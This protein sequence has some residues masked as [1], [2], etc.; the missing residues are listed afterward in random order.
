MEMVLSSDG[1]NTSDS[2]TTATETTTTA[3]MELHQSGPLSLPPSRR[4]NRRTATLIPLAL[5]LLAALLISIPAPSVILYTNAAPINSAPASAGSIPRST[6]SRH[7]LSQQRN[8][9]GS[10]GEYHDD[11]YDDDNYSYSYIPPWNLSKR[12]DPDGFLLHLYRCS[13]GEWEEE[14]AVGGRYSDLR[15]KSR[16]LFGTKSRH[17]NNQAAL[18]HD[19]EDENNDQQYSKNKARRHAI[20]L[21]GSSTTK[22]KKHQQRNSNS[23]EEEDESKNIENSKRRLARRQLLKQQQEH[24]GVDEESEY[25]MCTIRQVPGDGNCLFHSVSTCLSVVEDDTS[26]PKQ[27]QY[28]SNKHNSNSKHANS[29]HMDM[30][31]TTH[32]SQQS[33]WLRQQA[34]ECL[35]TRP[36]RVLFLQGR[37][38]LRAHELVEAAA[39]QYNIDATEYCHLMQQDSYWGGG[40]EIVAL[41]NVLRR[42]IHVYELAC[43]PRGWG[44]SSRSG[45]VEARDVS[46]SLLRDR[47]STPQ[48][49]VMRRMA[50]FGSPKFDRKE[51]LHILSADSRFPDVLPGK[52][53][54]AGNH[55]MALFPYSNTNSKKSGGSSKSRTKSHYRDRDAS[56]GSDGRRSSNNYNNDGNN[57]GKEMQ[58]G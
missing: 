19:E 16:F 34:V 6:N 45:H 58:R 2:G 39:A 54:S 57:N 41:S 18:L 55:F 38:C 8:E 27:H 9:Y 44:G 46:V 15:R 37:E 17:N 29:K 25:L 50:C 22:K 10:G 24:D 13:P 52:Q 32:L 7:A 36:K 40:P 43:V 33:A 12:I 35:R 1:T 31:N 3:M 20:P 48:Q 4:Q 49:F 26:T 56:S 5:V 47:D 21:G 14:A 51:P 30:R 23:E 42:P 53:L 28:N 11:E